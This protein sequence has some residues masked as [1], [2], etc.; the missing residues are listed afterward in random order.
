MWLL[1]LLFVVSMSLFRSIRSKVQNLT[2]SIH[3][4]RKKTRKKENEGAGDV[5]D[6]D[7]MI[8]KLKLER[9]KISEN[10]TKVLFNS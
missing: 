9:R 4:Q 2:D 10:I 8:A 7:I 3:K 1:I 5:E 6:A